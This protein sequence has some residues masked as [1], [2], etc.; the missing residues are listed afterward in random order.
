MAVSREVG[1]PADD[2]DLAV[3]PQEF[4]L[5]S[6]AVRFPRSIGANLK[7][8]WLSGVCGFALVE[9]PAGSR[10]RSQHPPGG[11]D[12]QCRQREEAELGPRS[13]VDRGRQPELVCHLGKR[14][15]RQAVEQKVSHQRRERELV[16]PCRVVER[17]LEDRGLGGR[18]RS[19]DGVR[20]QAHQAGALQDLAC[21]FQFAGDGDVGRDERPAR[22]ARLEQFRVAIGGDDEVVGLVLRRTRQDTPPARRLGDED[23]DPSRGDRTG[24]AGDHRSEHRGDLRGGG[25]ID[26]D[27]TGHRD[28]V[29]G[30]AG[31]RRDAQRTFH[32][33]LGKEPG[34]G[35]D[36]FGDRLHA[37]GSRSLAP[38]RARS[39][40][41]EPLGEGRTT[42]GERATINPVRHR[43]EPWRSRDGCQRNAAESRGAPVTATPLALAL[44]LGVNQTVVAP[45]PDGGRAEWRR[46]DAP[47][48]VVLPL[49][50]EG[51][52]RL[53][54]RVTGSAGN[55]DELRAANGP[56]KTPLTG[57][58]VR[59]PWPMLKGELRLAC[60][61]ALFPHD[62]RTAAGWEHE[63]VAPWGGDGESWWELA[64]WFCGGPVPLPRAPGGKPRARHVSAGRQPRRDSGRPPPAGVSGGAG[65]RGE[66]RDSSAAP[67]A[68]PAGITRSARTRK[69]VPARVPGSARLR[70]GAGRI[71]TQGEL[72]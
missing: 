33:F 69:P 50:G 62:R 57:I 14:N 24:E 15:P 67:D 40:K 34:R 8:L 58:R 41:G 31:P 29:G 11:I 7:P 44:L 27:L 60:A 35:G 51:W 32:R 1:R 20:G 6:S 68:E 59:V 42:A 46:G 4:G 17:D 16:F 52:T 12:D 25:E 56:L 23:R 18:T 9:K 22:P 55:A 28:P 64:D 61:R 26:G 47:R 30:K 21:R 54:L 37:Q 72:R 10:V 3:F 39:A 63:I 49:A 53:A 48:L 13:T 5:P 71:R 43:R 19:E 66:R 2:F 38:C 45:L 36:L 65:A 70:I